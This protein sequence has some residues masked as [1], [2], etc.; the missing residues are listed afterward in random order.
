MF[1]S[2][3]L[4][5]SVSIPRTTREIEILVR[6]RELRQFTIDGKST[7]GSQPAVDILF[8]NA[9]E[10]GATRYNLRVIDFT[11]GE[12][13]SSMKESKSKAKPLP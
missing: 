7:L 2:K 13:D 8:A 4:K 5:F 6:I 12:M 3:K 11:N 10:L 9:R 1:S